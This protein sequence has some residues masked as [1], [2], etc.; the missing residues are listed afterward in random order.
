MEEIT[1]FFMTFVLVLIIYQLF[2]VGPA[3]RRRSGKNNKKVDKE[4]FEIKYLEVRYKLN[5][6]K[7]DY[8][9]LLQICAITS[10]LD[11]AIMVS[12]VCIF[13]NVFIQL[14]VGFVSAIVL[15]IISYH[16]VYLFYK[17]KG[18]IIDGRNK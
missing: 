18:M 4:L 17:R 8:N 10:S 13:D 2:I 12:V 9:Q 15:I 1:L 6:N 5:M 11:I 14:L 7:I 16:L 3:K